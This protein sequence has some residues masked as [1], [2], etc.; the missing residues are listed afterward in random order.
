M[1]AFD[2]PTV[3]QIVLALI[4]C[5][6][7]HAAVDGIL[8]AGPWACDFCGTSDSVLACLRCSRMVKVDWKRRNGRLRIRTSEVGAPRPKIGWPQG[9]MFI[10]ADCLELLFSNERRL[11][12]RAFQAARRGWPMILRRS[13]AH[14][15]N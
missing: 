3:K 9:A 4:R 7:A 5:Y 13:D 6:R 8:R 1:M 10:C 2:T 14:R 12:E 11:L 15:W